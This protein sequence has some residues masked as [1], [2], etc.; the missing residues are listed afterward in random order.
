MENYG[1]LHLQNFVYCLFI[2]KHPTILFITWCSLNQVKTWKKGNGYYTCYSLGP[3]ETKEQALELPPRPFNKLSGL[4]HPLIGPNK[5]TKT[6]KQCVDTAESCC[7]MES[8][9]DTGR[10]PSCIFRSCVRLK[11]K[12]LVHIKKPVLAHPLGAWPWAIF[13]G[14]FNGQQGKPTKSST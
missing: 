8:Q 11:P 10:S 3:L 13:N 5:P 14:I 12:S 6:T 7:I 9:V 4:N 1:M 2:L